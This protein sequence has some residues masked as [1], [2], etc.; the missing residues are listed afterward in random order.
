MY[1]KI[2][3][4]RGERRF[5]GYRVT[6]KHY[7]PFLAVDMIVTRTENKTGALYGWFLEP[8]RDGLRSDPGNEKLQHLRVLTQLSGMLAKHYV[9]RLDWLQGDTPQLRAKLLIMPPSLFPT[10]GV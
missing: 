5:R 10:S 7:I 9:G 3:P 8:R 1:A 6:T 4:E 2:W